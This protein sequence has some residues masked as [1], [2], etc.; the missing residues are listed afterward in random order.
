M[1][2]GIALP[3]ESAEVG[4]CDGERAVIEELAYGLHRLADIA[5]ELGGGVA[6]DVDAG[7]RETGQA[8]IAP[9]TVVEG[10]AGDA[11]GTG[12]RLPEG[13]AGLHGREVL[14]DV[15]KR[16][17]DG[18]QGRT[19]QLTTAAQTALAEVAVEGGGVV[20]GDIAGCE[21]DDLGPASG[22]EDES[23]DD[24][25]VPSALSCVRDDVEELADL[26]SGEAAWCAGTRLGAL[27]GVAGIGLE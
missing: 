12:A 21:V 26:G 17:P 11:L 19:R 5:A 4:G 15:T 27:D 13:L 3:F 24:G 22:C 7:G 23:E 6:E 1:P 16:S 20:I 25:D 10:S 2:G 8:E 14:A 18:G 9:E